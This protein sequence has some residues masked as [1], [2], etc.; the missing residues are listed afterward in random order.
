[1]VKPLEDKAEAGVSTQRHAE[2][3]VFTVGLASGLLYEASPNLINEVCCSTILQ[4]FASIMIL[5]V[6]HKTKTHSE[7]LTYRELPLS[8]F[9]RTIPFLPSDGELPNDVAQ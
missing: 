2:I 9:P 3:N 8:A 7:V 4:I 1:M 6:L 5:S